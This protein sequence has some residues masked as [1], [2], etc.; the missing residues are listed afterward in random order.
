MKR[1]TMILVGAAGITLAAWGADRSI[2]RLRAPR[3]LP[4]ECVRGPDG[5]L[6]P[7]PQCRTATGTG[8]GFWSSGSGSSRSWSWGNSHSGSR[9]ASPSSGSHGPAVSRGGFGSSSRSFSSGS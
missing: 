9:T 2:N 7:L 1:S 4:P 3:P 6:P 8:R 5:A